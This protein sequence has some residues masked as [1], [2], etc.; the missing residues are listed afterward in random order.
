M[1]TIS[2]QKGQHFCFYAESGG[3]VRLNSGSLRVSQPIRWAEGLPLHHHCVLQSEQALSLRYPGWTWLDA[4]RDC[5]LQVKE[6]PGGDR[7]WQRLWRLLR[8]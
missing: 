4:Q 6:H 7:W 3:L 8:P 2:L 5:V 1:K